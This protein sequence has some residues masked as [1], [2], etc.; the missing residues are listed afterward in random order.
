[1]LSVLSGKGQKLSNTNNVHDEIR[2]T[3]YLS[4]L[5]YSDI[6]LLLL[7]LLSI[8]QIRNTK[9]EIFQ[10][11]TATA[12]WHT[13]P[14]SLVESDRRFRGTYSF[15]NQGDDMNITIYVCVCVTGGSLLKINS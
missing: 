7:R 12:F 1:M 3:R 6:E 2:R 4:G 11:L 9:Q 8:T 10:V 5:H 14:C 15:H 13:S